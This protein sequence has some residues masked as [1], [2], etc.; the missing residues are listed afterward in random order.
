MTREQ[1]IRHLTDEHHIDPV[2]VAIMA[3]PHMMF[4]TKGDLATQHKI[5]HDEQQG[6][7]AHKH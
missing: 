4:S 3:N 6:K 1:L 5:I 2:S 7:L